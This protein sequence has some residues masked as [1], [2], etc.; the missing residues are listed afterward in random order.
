MKN[1]LE[2]II[3]N[4]KFHGEKKSGFVNSGFVKTCNE[5][6]KGHELVQSTYECDYLCSTNEPQLG[7]FCSR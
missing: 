6:V 2:Q 1:H 5:L 4:G 3:T 7:V